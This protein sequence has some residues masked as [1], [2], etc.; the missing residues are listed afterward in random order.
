MPAKMPQ[1]A[2]LFC[3]F[4]GTLFLPLYM[5]F[6]RKYMIQIN[7]QQLNL[8]LFAPVKAPGETS[9]YDFSTRIKLMSE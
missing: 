5:H 9:N 1:A 8:K 2:I 3:L 6:Y 4:N 7:T